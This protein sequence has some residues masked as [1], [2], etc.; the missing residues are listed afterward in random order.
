MRVEPKKTDHRADDRETKDRELPGVSE[1]EHAEV[2]ACVDTAHDVA[3]NR[4]RPERDRAKTSDESVE[5][6]CDIH[7]VTGTGENKSRED[8]VQP[9]ETRHWYDN[10][11]FKERDGRRRARQVRHER[12]LPE[13]PTERHANDDLTGELVAFHEATV[14]LSLPLLLQLEVVI[15]QP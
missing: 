14:L 6:I 2:R 3:E 8:D 7:S 11:V 15:E 1:I 13:V 12:V 4:K 10:D 9:S 5:T